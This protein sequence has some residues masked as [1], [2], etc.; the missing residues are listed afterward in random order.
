MMTHTNVSYV[1]ISQSDSIKVMLTKF[2]YAVFAP[3][4]PGIRAKSITNC[5]QVIM[6]VTFYENQNLCYYSNIIQTVKIR[7][8]WNKKKAMRKLF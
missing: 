7:L 6:S 8:G 1:V 4:C 2:D 5:S 3:T